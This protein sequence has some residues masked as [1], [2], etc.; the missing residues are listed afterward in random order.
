M[1]IYLLS[2]EKSVSTQ[3]ILTIFVTRAMQEISKIIHTATSSAG[4]AV[5]ELAEALRLKFAYRHQPHLFRVRFHA[6][7]MK[8]FNYG[9]VRILGDQTVMLSTQQRMRSGTSV[10][11]LLQTSSSREHSVIHLVGCIIH[12]D[13][14]GHNQTYRCLIRVASACAKDINNPQAPSSDI[15]RLESA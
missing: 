6:P 1:L 3:R 10:N 13:P 9:M 15:A 12:V 5:R 8:K 11:V 4:S 7:G 2:E 14:P